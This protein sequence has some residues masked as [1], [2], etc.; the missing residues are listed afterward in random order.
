M[1][2]AIIGMV[3]LAINPFFLNNLLLNIIH[4]HITKCLWITGT[5]VS[6]YYTNT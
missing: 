1:W 6:A 4:K 5:C 2:K 3:L